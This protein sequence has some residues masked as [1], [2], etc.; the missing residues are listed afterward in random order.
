M[1]ASL[2]TR[3][4]PKFSNSLLQGLKVLLVVPIEQIQGFH[5][6]FNVREAPDFFIK[7][8]IDVI[9]VHPAYFPNENSSL[10]CFAPEFMVQPLGKA[11]GFAWGQVNESPG[12]DSNSHAIHADRDFAGEVQ[13]FV[14][15]EFQT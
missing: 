11:D 9:I 5:V 6:F 14:R 3:G 15:R 1:S 8:I 2:W 13:F 10:T 7:M 12:R 4:L